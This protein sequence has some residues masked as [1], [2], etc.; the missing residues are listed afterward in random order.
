ML[1]RGILIS[2]LLYP[3]FFS[4][5]DGFTSSVFCISS[6]RQKKSALLNTIYCFIRKIHGFEEL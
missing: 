2:G 4:S 1:P 6:N 5:P 3:I